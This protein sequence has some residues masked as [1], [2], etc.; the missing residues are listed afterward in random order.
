ML[1]KFEKCVDVIQSIH[2]SPINTIFH[3]GAHEGQEAESYAQFNVKKVAWF[4]A[5]PNLISK[6][7]A[8]VNKFPIENQ[9]IPYALWD[10]TTEL[11][12]NITNYDQSSSIFAL[13]KHSEYYPN[14]FVNQ[15]IMINAFRLDSLIEVSPKY[16]KWDDFDFINIDTQGAELAILRGFGKYLSSTKLKAIYL[17]VNSEKL[18]KNI[19]LVNE[20]DDFLKNFDFFRCITSWTQSGWGDAL[21][22]KRSTIN[23]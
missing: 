8:H 18:Y 23:N 20:I 22:L 16:L 17:E 21:Y 10:K 12:F 15:K 14:I 4:E 9:I 6:L 13:D 2:N 1:I 7:E 3:I 19:P 5:N 11:E